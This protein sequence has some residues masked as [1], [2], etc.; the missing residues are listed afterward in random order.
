VA[1]WGDL[2]AF[3]ATSLGNVRRNKLSDFVNVRSSGLIAMKLDEGDKLISVRC[4]TSYDDVL[5]ATRMGRAVRFPVDVV[6]VFVGRASSGVRGIRLADGDEVMSM[7]ILRHVDCTPD[8]RTAYFKQ[9]RAMLAAEGEDLNGLGGGDEEEGS[10]DFVLSQERF[11]Q[12]LSQE[13]YLLTVSD[14]GYGKRSSAYA[15]RTSGRGVQGITN[16]ML[17][18]K[19]GSVVAT[20]PVKEDQ[21]VM[22]VTD[23]G[24]V[25]RM[26]I[27][28]VRITGR[29]S[30]GVIMFRVTE[31]EKIVSVAVLDAESDDEAVDETASAPSAP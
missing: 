18:E 5:L 25:I 12:L 24:Q 9:R 15:Y 1:P 7:S 2:D 11:E 19:N 17:T 16:M 23:G 29:S 30:Q 31:G 22:M 27:H 3:F 13:E 10:S 14:R 26:P 21:E 20:F 8:E 28:D 6:R 4:C